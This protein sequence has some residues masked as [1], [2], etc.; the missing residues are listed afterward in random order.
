MAAEN[1]LIFND[2]DFDQEV[3]DSSIPV[4]VDF[5][6]EWCPPCRQMA[7][8]LD[9]VATANLGKAK[10]GK[11]DVVDNSSTAARYQVRGIPTL[12]LFKDGKVIQEHV[13]AL[14]QA[15]LQKMLEEHANGIA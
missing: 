4:L 2:A 5:W 15:D 1:T 13:G 7:P 10:V 11:L 3:L 12:L 14:S 6:A 8:A 9:A